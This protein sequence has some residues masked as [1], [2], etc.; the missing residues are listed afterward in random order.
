MRAACRS[1]FEVLWFPPAS[2]QGR[3]Q[4]SGVGPLGAQSGNKSAVRK[5]GVNSRQRLTKPRYGTG[6]GRARRPQSPKNRQQHEVPIVD[7]TAAQ[8]LRRFAEK[9][10][11]AGTAVFL[12]GA[13]RGVARSLL[14]VGLKKPLVPYATS[15]AQ[16][17]SHARV[18]SIVERGARLSPDKFAEGQKRTSRRPAG[19]S[20]SDPQRTCRM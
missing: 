15:T 5:S 6:V 20:A 18:R 3:H 9:L 11:K 2:G 8:T 4:T 12:T 10:T 13:S 17:L 7:S 19:M 14:Q 16:A 1:K